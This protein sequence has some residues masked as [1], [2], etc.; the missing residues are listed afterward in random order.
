ML[1]DFG[2]KNTNLIPNNDIV[3]II[4]LQTRINRH[5]AVMVLRHPTFRGGMQTGICPH[6][7]ADAGIAILIVFPISTCSILRHHALPDNLNT[8]R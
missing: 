3:G 8:I 4:F 1:V 5:T 7:P 6:A 2:C